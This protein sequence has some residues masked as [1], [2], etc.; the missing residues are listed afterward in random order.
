MPLGDL[1]ADALL[2]EAVVYVRGSKRLQILPTSLYILHR[3]MGLMSDGA[4]NNSHVLGYGCG[5]YKGCSKPGLVAGLGLFFS[6]SGAM[7]PYMYGPFPILLDMA[8]MVGVR[9]P[10]RR[11]NIPVQKPYFSV[12][13]VPYGPV[14]TRTDPYEPIWQLVTF[15]R[16]CSSLYPFHT[17]SCS[18][19]LACAA[20]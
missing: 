6:L 7:G 10:V 11:P 15:R 16:P 12:R 14:R 3:R 19:L 9:E 1:W 17:G 20:P 2:D 18:A 4:S 13:F 8:G 5:L